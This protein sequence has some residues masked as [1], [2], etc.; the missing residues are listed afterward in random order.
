MML[1]IYH[2]RQQGCPGHMFELV[3]VQDTKPHL[4]LSVSIVLTVLNEARRVESIASVQTTMVEVAVELFIKSS[5]VAAVGW[6]ATTWV[7]NCRR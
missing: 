5:P 4:A 6:S 2:V 3:I 1:G 7:S